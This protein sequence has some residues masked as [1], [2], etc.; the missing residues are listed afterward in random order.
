MKGGAMQ[1]RKLSRWVS[2]CVL[3]L[4]VAA[5]AV[6]V[7]QARHAPPE[8]QLGTTTAGYVD[9]ATR[10]H[11]PDL[12]QR[13]TRIVVAQAAGFDWGDAGIGAGGALGVVLL[14]GGS[15]LVLKRNRPRLRWLF[16]TV[17]FASLFGAGIA[18][19][20]SASAKS[21]PATFT[22]PTGDSGTAPDIANVVVSNDANGQITFRINVAK[23]SVP[24]PVQIVVAIDSDENAAT[25]QSGTDYLLLAD[26]ASNAFG[27]ARW[28]GTDFVD[29]AAPTATATNDSAGIA[30]AINR[31]DLGN[32]SGLNFWV[33]AFD[34]PEAVAGHFDDAPDDGTWN[35]R[36]V[37]PAPLA[38]TVAGFLAPRSV[39]AGKTLTA[40]MAAKRSDTGDL[41]GKE[42]RVKCRA[43]TGGKSL[44]LLASGFVKVGSQSGAGCSWRVPRNARR[45]AIHGSVTIS[46]QGATVSR[47]FTARIK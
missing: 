4:A 44:R 33:R 27:L 40:V 38:L 24:S 13:P 12:V 31:S 43:T 3:T 39:K 29:A 2:L 46:Y 28:N 5:I 25:G 26:L 34:G 45:K 23:L 35:Y 9:A 6:P 30:F 19:Y 47:Q 32:A 16:F 17:V 20:A 36:L 37:S 42:G 8:T 14:A 18:D 22:D 41:V 15:A 1:D 11:H 7:A 21:N 10:H